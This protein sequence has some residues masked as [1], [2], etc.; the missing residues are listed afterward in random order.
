ML[1]SK[2]CHFVLDN[3]AYLTLIRA[4]FFFNFYNKIFVYLISAAYLFGA[5]ALH[6]LPLA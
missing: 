4:L 6:W 1:I 5:R 3:L 2:I